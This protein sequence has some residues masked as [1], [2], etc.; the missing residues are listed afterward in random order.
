MTTD[1][2]KPEG[3]GYVDQDGKLEE[4]GI[5]A[6]SLEQMEIEVAAPGEPGLLG[7]RVRLRPTGELTGALG[8]LDTVI[9][10]KRVSK[11]F[12]LF[13]WPRGTRKRKWGLLHDQIWFYDRR[14][15]QFWD[16]IRAYPQEW[17]Q[18]AHG[19]MVWNDEVLPIVDDVGTPW[20]RHEGAWMRLYMDR[21]MLW[22]GPLKF[23]LHHFFSGD[24]DSAEHDH[25]WAFVTFPLGDYYEQITVDDFDPRMERG[26][27]H[28]VVRCV[29]RWRLHF[30][31]ALFKHIVLEPKK[32]FR[33][34][35]IA[36]G[37]DRRWGFWPD[38]QT[39]VPYDEWTK[40]V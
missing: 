21:H 28:K 40:Y 6:S 17:H 38:P 34:L 12:P 7:G 19:M 39:F 32:P 33:T 22:L 30:R 14:G 8:R 31:P 10:E 26:S 20:R 3:R 16:A 24:D 4:S 11:V 5:S 25:P 15:P 37:K 9:K 36:W 13:D 27:Y 29:T 23:R 2:D 18:T 1:T 35:V